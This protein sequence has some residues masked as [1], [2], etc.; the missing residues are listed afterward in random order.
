MIVLDA[1]AAI[2]WLLGRDLGEQVAQRLL[3][4]DQSVHVPHLWSVEVAQ[5]LRRF[6]RSGTLTPDRA[7]Q[8]VGDAKDLPA[9]RYPHEPLLDRAWQLRDNMTIYDGVYLALAEALDAPL[10][11]TDER[12]Q[13]SPGHDANVD[14][15]TGRPS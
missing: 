2:E 7:R 12:M 3:A 9:A 13:S 10:V 5:V 4:P 8:A 11:T 6:V 15:I 1:S 14:L